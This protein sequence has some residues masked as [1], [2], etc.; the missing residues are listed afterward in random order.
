MADGWAK[1]WLDPHLINGTL[2]IW[3]Q[4]Y[5]NDLYVGKMFNPGWDGSADPTDPY[6]MDGG[7]F[8][9]ADVYRIKFPK[10]EI[11][12]VWYEATQLPYQ[13]SF[14]TH[15][16]ETIPITEAAGPSASVVE[17]NLP[18][19]LYA[20]DSITGFARVENVGGVDGTLRCLIITEWDGAI[21]SAEQVLSPGQVL[22]ANLPAGIVMPT[23]DALTTIKGE[24]LENGV[25]I[26]DDVKTH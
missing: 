9:V 22:Q 1:I 10:Q 17:V 16:E 24:H 7:P 14:A 15:L 5:D 6:F 8:A 20:G 3:Y 4:S 2:E 19:Q 26:T 11:G 18:D 12:G 23:Q 25:W 13:F 21:Y